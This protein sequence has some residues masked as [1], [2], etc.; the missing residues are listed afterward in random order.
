[1][2]FSIP[3]GI[4]TQRFS[5]EDQDF[6][7]VKLGDGRT[8]ITTNLWTPINIPVVG[9]CLNYRQDTEFIPFSKETYG[10]RNP[11]PELKGDKVHILFD[12]T[13][14]IDAMISQLEEIKQELTDYYE[15][16]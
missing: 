13:R 3:Y 7:V 4:S 11:A 10:S 8:S 1:M 12:N 15:N 9:I 5:D 16:S 14:S 2:P 6:K